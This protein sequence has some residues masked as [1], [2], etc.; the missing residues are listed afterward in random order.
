MLSG[1][2]VVKDP[3]ASGAVVTRTEM[4]DDLRTARVYVRLLAG[5]DEA[6]RRELL[7]ALRRASG[8]I[9]RE[10]TRRLRLRFAPELRFLYDDGIDATSRIEELLNEIRT[11]RKPG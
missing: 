4:S 8:L 10:V 5:D 9:R 7:G 6:R 1:G 11:E 3:R 2:A